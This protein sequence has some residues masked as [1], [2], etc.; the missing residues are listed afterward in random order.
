MSKK[1]QKKAKKLALNKTKKH[2]FICC[3]GADE[4]CTKNKEGLKS[5]KYLKKRLAELNLEET[6]HRTKVDC[7]GICSKGPIA[8]IY[9]EGLW[10]HS[11]TPRALEKIL[12]EHIIKGKP[13]EEYKIF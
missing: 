2:I 9:P 13:V 12:H 4:K 11:C 5:L 10:Y 3:G 8:V 7:F 1:L 6:I